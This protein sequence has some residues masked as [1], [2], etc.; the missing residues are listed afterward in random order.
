VAT[1]NPSYV[2]LSD[3]QIRRLDGSIE[4]RTAPDTVVTAAVCAN[5]SGRIHLGTDFWDT[6]FGGSALYWFAGSDCTSSSGYLYTAVPSGW[7]DKI[8][9]AA[10]NPNSRCG[11]WIHYADNYS[12]K[13]IDCG[14][15]SPR[16]VYYPCYDMYL[17]DHSSMS[18][19]TSTERWYYHS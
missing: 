8:S 11:N 6:H 13:A 7:N 1:G 14:W 5:C 3:A 10:I 2:S 12:G 19:R 4:G 9:S 17:P 15:A 18:D 16:G